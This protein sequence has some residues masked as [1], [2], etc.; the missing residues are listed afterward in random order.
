M[1]IIIGVIGKETPQRIREDKL[2]PT[3]VST[4]QVS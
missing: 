1:E 2:V 3:N 4:I